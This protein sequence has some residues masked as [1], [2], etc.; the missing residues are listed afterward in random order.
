[1]RIATHL[2]TMLI[3]FHAG[4]ALAHK[5]SDSYLR[6][7]L[8]AD[9][10]H[11]EGQWDIALRDLDFAL[12]LDRDRDGVLTWGEVRGART[13]ITE[14]ALA[15]LKVE[16]L[17]SGDRATCAL[18]ARDLLIDQHVDGYYAV[19]R[20][21]AECGVH[22]ERLIVHYGLLFDVDATHR[23]LLN[24][25]GRGSE[26]ADV[27]SIDAPVASLSFGSPSRWSQFRGFVVEGIW[28]ILKGYDHI[29]FL[30]TLL[31]PAVLRYGQTGWMPRPSLRES[32]LDV[33]K[34][35]TAFTIAHSLTLTLATLGF[36]H[37]PSRWV[38][39]AIAVTV[40][41]GALNNLRPVVTSRRWAVAFAFGLIHGFGF[42]S[43][44]AD[45]GIHGS[46]LVLALVGFNSGV[47][48]GQLLIVGAVLPLAFVG[49]RSAVYR[50]AFMPAGAA[51]IS[52]LAGYWLVVRLAADTFG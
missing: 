40:L 28:H 13:Q 17:G 16:V 52:V 15:R 33:L 2:L 6:L 51:A 42:A 8:P 3:A 38:E 50:R 11:L 36:V 14:Y 44:L 7:S 49:R 19:I 31:F 30:L 23:G 20:F 22:P 41:L 27:L 12:D 18:T 48:V 26:Q 37:L 34:I 10:T 1:V 46:N 35:V 29:L 45:L 25:S 32:W 9:A 4:A 5:P 43:V 47:E 39:S 21:A 24:V